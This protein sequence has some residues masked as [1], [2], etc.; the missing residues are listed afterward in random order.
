MSDK[1]YMLIDPRNNEPFYVGNT[2]SSLKERLANHLACRNNKRQYKYYETIWQIYN[3]RLHLNKKE[4]KPIIVLLDEYE[5]PE[6][7]YW[8]GYWIEQLMAWGFNILN[9]NKSSKAKQGWFYK[10]NKPKMLTMYYRLKKHL[11]PKKP[12]AA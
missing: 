10:Q 6:S 11:E 12:V 8:E 2:G 3:S 1:I 7:C 4:R 9:Y 5:F